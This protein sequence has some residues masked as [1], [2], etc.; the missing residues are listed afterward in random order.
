M[1][2][3]TASGNGITVVG[4]GLEPENI[5]RLQGG[6]PIRVKFSDRRPRGVTHAL[7]TIRAS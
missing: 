3:F 5:T 4:I 6:Q 2:K 7:A 1:I